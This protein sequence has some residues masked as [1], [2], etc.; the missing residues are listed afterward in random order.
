M[1]HGLKWLTDRDIAAALESKTV[2]SHHKSN[3]FKEILRREIARQNE[4]M[5]DAQAQKVSEAAA[6]N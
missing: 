5:A 4:E 2:S 1:K 6:R 3:L